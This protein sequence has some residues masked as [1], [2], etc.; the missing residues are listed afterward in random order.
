MKGS[1]AAFLLSGNTEH[2]TGASN[3]GSDNHYKQ[4][5]NNVIKTKQNKIFLF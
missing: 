5:Q 2:L 4:E 3:P 1:N